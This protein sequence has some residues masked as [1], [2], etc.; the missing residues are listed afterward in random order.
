M[1]RQWSARCYGVARQREGSRQ[2]SIGV[3]AFPYLV[4]LS[5]REALTGIGPRGAMGSP[6]NG[7]GRAKIAGGTRVTLYC[8]SYVR[9]R[10]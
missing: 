2:N 3:A 7:R 6:A 10:R 9:A 8:C 4:T 1:A 5:A